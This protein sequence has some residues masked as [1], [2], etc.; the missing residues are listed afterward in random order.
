LERFP[1][2]AA[3]LLSSRTLGAAHRTA[4]G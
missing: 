3:E 1:T 4:A 2:V